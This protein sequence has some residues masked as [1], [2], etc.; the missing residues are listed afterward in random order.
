MCFWC[1]MVNQYKS[2]GCF[3]NFSSYL[4]ARWKD[5]FCMFLFGLRLLKICI[6]HLP[7]NLHS[8]ALLF[9][10]AEGIATTKLCHCIDFQSYLVSRLPKPYPTQWHRSCASL[11]HAIKGS[12]T[13]RSQWRNEN[14]SQGEHGIVLQMWRV[15]AM[16]NSKCEKKKK[17][18]L[19]AKSYGL[20]PDKLRGLNYL[21]PS[22]FDVHNVFTDYNVCLMDAGLYDNFVIY[23]VTHF[24]FF[25]ILQHFCIISYSQKLQVLQV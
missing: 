12:S 16:L 25:Y 17:K 23:I 15:V 2:F 8:L 4:F 13:P 6:L 7:S 3:I 18:H 20:Y 5:V 14:C 19:T 9:L 10:P 21:H 22:P 1:P 24:W 11:T